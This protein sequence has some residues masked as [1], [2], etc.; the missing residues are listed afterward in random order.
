MQIDT[1]IKI[2]CNLLTAGTTAYNS[3]NEWLNMH[4]EETNHICATCHQPIFML[5]K[6]QYA[7][8]LIAFD[9]SGHSPWIASGKT[10]ISR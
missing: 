1:E 4:K 7:L 6:L 3:I 8:P 5:H 9:L 2:K 10:D